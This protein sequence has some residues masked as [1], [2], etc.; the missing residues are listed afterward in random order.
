MELSGDTDVR[1]LDL[2]N[3]SQ[4][5]RG[6]IRPVPISHP[7]HPSVNGIEIAPELG[8]EFRLGGV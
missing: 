1:I 7:V 3:Y 2:G 5:W 4:G 6:N 8:D